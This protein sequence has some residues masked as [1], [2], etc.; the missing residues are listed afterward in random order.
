MRICLQSFRLNLVWLHLH[1][2]NETR[3]IKNFVLGK[4]HAYKIVGYQKLHCRLQTGFGRILDQ[5]YQSRSSETFVARLARAE[6]PPSTL[7]AK[8]RPP[9]SLKLLLI[10][11]QGC[12]NKT[13]MA[14]DAPR[15]DMFCS[16][17]EI[18]ITCNPKR[19]RLIIHMRHAFCHL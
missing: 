2:L 17:K 6:T 12:T 19:F 9:K 7:T 5:D 8:I 13:S 16:A 14:M 11:G 18:C 1:W 10:V 15:M 3:E 4:V